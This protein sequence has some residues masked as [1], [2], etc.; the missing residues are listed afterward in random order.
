[1][2]RK[3]SMILS[4]IINIAELNCNILSKERG[5]NIKNT[6]QQIYGVN[7]GGEQ[8]KNVIINQKTNSSI[9]DTETVYINETVVSTATVFEDVK[10]YGNESYDLT[11]T[12][13]DFPVLKVT[14]LKGT[15]KTKTVFATEEVDLRV[16]NDSIITEVWKEDNELAT[17][18]KTIISTK[19]IPV[20]VS[21]ARIMIYNGLEDDGLK[22]IHTANVIEDPITITVT[23]INTEMKTA[24]ISASESSS[25]P[26]IDILL[27]NK[28]KKKLMIPERTRIQLKK[29]VTKEKGD[30]VY[31]PE[32]IVVTQEKITTVLPSPT[33]LEDS[34]YVTKLNEPIV[35]DMPR[36]QPSVVSQLYTNAPSFIPKNISVSADIGDR[37]V[38]S[39]LSYSGHKRSVKNIH[40]S[41]DEESME[42]H[43]VSENQ[44]FWDSDSEDNVPSRKLKDMRKESA[45]EVISEKEASSFW[46]SDSEDKNSPPTKMR[47]RKKSSKRNKTIGSSFLNRKRVK[48]IEESFE[49]FYNGNSESSVSLTEGFFVSGTP[50]IKN[51]Q[52]EISNEASTIEEIE[53]DDTSILNEEN[54]LYYNIKDLRFV[55]DLVITETISKQIVKIKGSKTPLLWII[56]S[57][58]EKKDILNLAYNYDNKNPKMVKLHGVV[59]KETGDFA[60]ILVRLEG[61]NLSYI[62]SQIGTLSED[63]AIFYISEILAELRKSYKNGIY[64]KR[65]TGS[66]T[67][68]RKDGHIVLG[69]IE[70]LITVNMGNKTDV[71]STREREVLLWLGRLAHRMLFKNI[72]VFSG[73]FDISKIGK[74]IN[75][76]SNKNIQYPK[77]KKISPEFK[78]FIDKTI[79]WKEFP[80]LNI[81]D[82]LGLSIFD[83]ISWEDIE[84][85]KL[86]PPFLTVGKSE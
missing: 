45:K 83:G 38:Q 63:Q 70:N 69:D 28:E 56:D 29:S 3:Y 12:V 57:K 26:L 61:S 49:N 24:I 53:N 43:D 18:T 17:S 15:E 1:M 16:D 6:F 5:S 86:I 71:L 59:K 13:T 84:D 65:I 39:N 19:T 80:N 23:S 55:K 40:S 44:S 60:G 14:V 31:K 68:L 77:D 35:V 27:A 20:T 46:D 78:E 8:M 85:E 48:K 54:I 66:S 37:F 36:L 52:A 81:E 41:E 9:V 51:K 22:I 82:I 4:G 34:P 32:T 33:I 42:S 72:G 62:L 30:E 50:D 7:I 64:L 67:Q 76:I 47:N 74:N 2:I 10:L 21:E 75:R 73:N 79:G 58:M 11:V 25:R